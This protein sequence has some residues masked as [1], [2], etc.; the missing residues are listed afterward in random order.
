M[1]Y[2]ILV[3]ASPDSEAGGLPD[4][5]VVAAMA[6]YHEQLAKAGVLLDAAGLHSSAKGWR[7]RHADGRRIVRDGPF[8]EAGELVAA[9]TLI[10]VHSREEALEWSRRFPALH[11]NGASAEIEVRQLFEVDDFGDSA[12]AGRFCDATTLTR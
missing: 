6:D 10:Q 4:E 8:A 11:V 1:R 2:M 12:A 5:S 3:K 9:Y 7:I